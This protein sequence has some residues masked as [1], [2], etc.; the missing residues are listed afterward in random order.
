MDQNKCFLP[1]LVC[2]V[3]CHIKREVTGTFQNAI[4]LMDYS[5]GSSED[6]TAGRSVVRKDCAR[7]LLREE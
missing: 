7:G 6:H 2:Q 1:K 5:V 3:L 4:S